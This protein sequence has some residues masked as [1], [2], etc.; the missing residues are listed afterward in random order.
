MLKT[1]AVASFVLCVKML[2]IIMVLMIIFE[3]MKN[4]HLIDRI[5]RL[6]A[7]L[8][9]ILGLGKQSGFLWLTAA[10]FGLTYGAAVIVEEVREG[11]LSGS[12][13]ER[14]HLS[15]GI[16]HAM[17]EDAAVFMTLGLG[18]FWL[19]VPRLAAAVIVVQL[20]T[21]FKRLISQPGFSRFLPWH[22]R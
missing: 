6:M 2:A 5:V 13:L 15:I 14:L 3:V 8:L 17:V 19:S 20:Y 9:K 7:P 18:L 12:E 10:L 21:L 16:N 22:H 1:W 11:S 4:Y